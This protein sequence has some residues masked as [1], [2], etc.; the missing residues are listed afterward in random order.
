[1]LYSRDVWTSEM[2][3]QLSQQ[4]LHW[5]LVITDIAV[6]FIVWG[7]KDGWEN[8]Y[9]SSSEWSEKAAE[10]PHTSWLAT[11][12]NYLSYHNLSVEDATELALDRPPWRLLEAS[13]GA[14][15]IGASL[16]M[17]MMWGCECVAACSCIKQLDCGLVVFSIRWKK[18]SWFIKM[19]LFFRTS[20]RCRTTLWRWLIFVIIY[21]FKWLCTIH[22][23]AAVIGHV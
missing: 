4:Q 9:S 22:V 13:E 23:K 7:C 2:Y 10:R 5:L 20:R 21:W 19:P 16:T 14:H 3:D 15:W 6:I 8:S 1:M 18:L 12:K 17:V 11:K